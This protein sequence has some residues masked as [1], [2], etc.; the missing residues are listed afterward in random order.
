MTR[1]EVLEI[2]GIIDISEMVGAFVLHLEAGKA[3]SVDH[4]DKDWFDTQ[5][6]QAENLDPDPVEVFQWLMSR[7][8]F[9]G[10]QGDLMTDFDAKRDRD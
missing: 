2:A 10:V 4:G 1:T 8:G 9:G 3:G 7:A 5:I 6:K